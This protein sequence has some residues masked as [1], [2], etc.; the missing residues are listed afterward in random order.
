MYPVHLDTT[1]ENYFSDG[2]ILKV[3]WSYLAILLIENYK[4]RC[5]RCVSPR[6][7]EYPEFAGFGGH[8]K[9]LHPKPCEGPGS[10]RS[11]S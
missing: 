1:Q 5:V 10:A 2:A 6:S 11:S 8:S 4:R 3:T 9:K 7:L